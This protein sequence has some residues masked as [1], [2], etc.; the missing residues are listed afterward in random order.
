MWFKELAFNPVLLRPIPEVRPLLQAYDP[1]IA[2][3]DSADGGEGDF[4]VPHHVFNV[5]LDSAAKDGKLPTAPAALRVMGMKG[6]APVASYDLSL[7]EERPELLQMNRDG[8]YFELMNSALGLL[9]SAAEGRKNVG[10]LSLVR[11]PALN[12]EALRLEFSGRTKSLIVILPR[13]SYESFE[14]GKVYEEDEFLKL[15]QRAA[16]KVRQ[17]D[18]MGA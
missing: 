14:N 9:K 18:S 5:A 1:S 4:G 7:D 16:S 12:M 13:F 10:E 6:D 8:A 2:P 3:G 17:D 15:L 11:I